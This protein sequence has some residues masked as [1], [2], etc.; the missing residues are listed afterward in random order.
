[1]AQKDQP[2][3][4][5]FGNLGADPKEHESPAKTGTRSVYDPVTDTVTE[6]DYSFEARSFVTF[7]VAVQVEGM[8]EPRWIPC[9]DWEPKDSRQFLKGDRVRLTGHF[10]RRSFTKEG[11]TKTIKQF[12][13]A[14]ASLAKPRNPQAE[15]KGAEV[16]QE[17]APAS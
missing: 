2:T 15:P 16:A 17:A 10:E 8:V 1:M 6:Q 3:V 9:V 4:T 5:I 14:T 12:V 13:V 11:E 7:N